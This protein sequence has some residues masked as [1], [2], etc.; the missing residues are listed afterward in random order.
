MVS[1]VMKKKY[2]P[3]IETLCCR[4]YRETSGVLEHNKYV[5][6]SVNS[7][8]H[9][10]GWH[11]FDYVCKQAGIDKIN[12]TKMRHYIATAMDQV[13]MSNKEKRTM[14]AQFGHSSAIHE[15]IYKSPAASMAI[16]LSQKIETVLGKKNGEN[17]LDNV[18]HSETT[19]G[20]D[21]GCRMQTRKRTCKQKAVTVDPTSEFEEDSDDHPEYKE[22]S[23]SSP[24]SSEHEFAT[25]KKIKNAPATGKNRFKFLTPERNVLKS[26]FESYIRGDD[27][28]PRPIS[29]NLIPLAKRKCFPSLNNMPTP[30]KVQKLRTTVY[31]YKRLDKE[32]N[33]RA[34]KSLFK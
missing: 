28:S 24:D 4:S 17:S 13:L 2:T 10:S 16:L 14:L 1:I 23:S 20:D 21:V 22:A 6:P 33:D 34:V 8:S 27:C 7:P 31:N 32:K 18:E 9:C 5:F 19:T 12:A 30:Q 15:S 3:L 26:Y 29:K 11:E 25:P